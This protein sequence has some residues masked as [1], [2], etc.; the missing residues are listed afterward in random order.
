LVQN[1]I[2][3]LNF[4]E[5]AY[6]PQQRVEEFL[7]NLLSVRNGKLFRIACREALSCK[8]SMILDHFGCPK[9][10]QN[11]V[12][13]RELHPPAEQ[14]DELLQ[15]KGIRSEDA[16]VSMQGLKNEYVMYQVSSSCSRH[17]W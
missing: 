6:S 3:V 11:S 8:K 9:H 16:P 15:F 14:L 13:L 1:K 4:L 17:Q 10:I 12:R 7:D 2:I 5:L